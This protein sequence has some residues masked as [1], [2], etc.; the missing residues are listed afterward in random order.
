[1]CMCCMGKGRGC[2]GIVSTTRDPCELKDPGFEDV[3]IDAIDANS[4]S[5]PAC[6]SSG[7]LKVAGDWDSLEF[8][9]G[10]VREVPLVRLED[11][12]ERDSLSL[13]SPGLRG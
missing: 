12:G 6:P 8:R 2:M 7:S 4:G 5:Y 1:M 13:S 9:D 11:L 3:G 10:D